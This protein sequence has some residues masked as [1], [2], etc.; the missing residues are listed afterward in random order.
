MNRSLIVDLFVE[1]RA[2]E[3]FLKPLIHR[4]A[5]DENVIV[6]VRPRSA[7][8]GHGRAIREYEVYQ[9]ILE[10]GLMSDEQPDVIVV[11]IDGN[12]ATFNKKRD[13]IIDST[14]ALFRE[15][16][17]TACPDPH[18]ERW[19]LAD[20]ESFYQVVGTM[21]KVEKRKCKRDY[22]KNI[23]VQAIR[24]AGHPINLGGIEFAPE[25]T[26]AMDLYRAG[27]NHHCLKALIDGLRA[28]FRQADQA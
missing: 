15:R 10:K 23:L 22:Y 14:K 1:D 9:K 26:E 24:S 16:L 13:E 25:L 28:K 4:I 12:C 21:P 6:T 2:H 8:G 20:P 11:A 17:V 27:Q 7:R 3:E 18:V 19:Y 5:R